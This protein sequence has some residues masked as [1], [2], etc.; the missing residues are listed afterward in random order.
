MQQTS[1]NQ[2]KKLDCAS[3]ASKMKIEFVE[4]GWCLVASGTHFKL[5]KQH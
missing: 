3:I 5:V 2:R 1:H 4:V